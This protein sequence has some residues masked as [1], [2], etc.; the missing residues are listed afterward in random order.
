MAG[1]LLAAAIPL[2][3]PPPPPPII[4]PG[5][6]FPGTD[7]ENFEHVLQHVTG[8]TTVAQGDRILVNAGTRTVCDLLLLDEESLT[9]VLTNNTN[10]MVRMRLK[11][12]KQGLEN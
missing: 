11:A 12:L 10:Q 7:Q 4:A 5:G 2:G 3:R 6:L 8:L 9:S 1:I